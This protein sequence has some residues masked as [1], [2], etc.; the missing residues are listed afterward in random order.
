M[1]T[2]MTIIAVVITF[3]GIFAIVAAVFK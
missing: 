2:L 1:I 3:V